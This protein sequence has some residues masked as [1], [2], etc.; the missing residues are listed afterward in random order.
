MAKAFGEAL[1]ALEKL[2]HEVWS[3]FI[4][5]VVLGFL[6]GYYQ[7]QWFDWRPTLI[8]GRLEGCI[9]CLIFLQGGARYIED[10]KYSVCSFWVPQGNLGRKTNGGEL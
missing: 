6:C 1:Q 4:S 8:V 10:R 9:R 7:T 5:L 3:G 2:R